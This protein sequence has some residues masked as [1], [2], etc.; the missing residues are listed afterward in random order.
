MLVQR[1][2]LLPVLIFL[3]ISLVILFSY[4]YFSIT[5]SNV[6]STEAE[7]VRMQKSF[8]QQI[9]SLEDTALALAIEAANNPDIQKA[10]A[11]QDRAR[12]Q[13]LTM[14]SYKQ[15]NAEFDIPQY[16]YHLPPA[17]SFLRLHQPERFGDDLSAIRATVVEANTTLKPVSGLE[18]GRGGLGI[19]G[20]VPVFY[21][22]RH[23]GAVEFGLN[24]NAPLFQNLK[25]ELGVDWQLYLEKTAAEVATFE[26]ATESIT[27]PIPELLLQ[28]STLATPLQAPQEAYQQ[29]LLGN[30]SMNQ[31]VVDDLR[32]AVMTAPLYD[33]SGQIIGVLEIV[34]DRTDFIRTNQTNLVISLLTILLVFGLAVSLYS[35]A[36]RRTLQPIRALV[37]TAETIASG[38]LNKTVEIKSGDEFEELGSVFNKMTG[39]LREFILNLEKRV[40]ERTADIEQSN[41]QL[42]RRSEELNILNKNIE[43]R[44]K[45][46]ETISEVS[47]AIASLEET[48]TLLPRITKI[49]SEKFGFYHVGIFLLDESRQFA[50]LVAS[51]SEGGQ[52]M[53]A[54]NHRLEVGKVGIV[55]YVTGTGN[56]RIALDTGQ[57]A[58]FFNNPD[59]PETHSEMALPLKSSR[60]VVGALD[61]Q[62][63][64][65]E[66]FTDDDL[67]VLTVLA[68]QVSSAIENARVYE[69][70]Q[71]SMEEVATIYR[72]YIRQEWDRLANREETLGYRYTI[73]GAKPILEKSAKP[74][75]PEAT[76]QKSDEG[77]LEVPIK[78]RDETIGV[79]NIR[80]P[81]KR[82]WQEDEIAI[83]RAVADRVAISAENARL[84]E[85]T[86][87]RA[88]RERKVS[89]ITS[90]IRSTNDPNEMLTIALNEIKQALKV[91][92]VKIVPFNPAKELD[93][94]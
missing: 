54:R 41:E 21:E 4:T 6:S 28:T 91:K 7:L 66:A 82:D 60:G 87:E 51:N 69:A 36:L 22:G 14:E 23:I 34:L 8:A 29:A 59:L 42:A 50:I 77:L 93:Q 9:N 48:E 39:Q 62:S 25:S 92:D 75:L 71:K 56:P 52:R 70:T 1:K 16:Q 46:L 45:Q 11:E 67:Q 26:S 94:D 61:V 76:E 44:A 3:L 12:L 2:L 17:T 49:I 57:D 68:N 19:R 31:V 84:F 89:E 5:T 35:L 30:R 18:I 13:A 20:V 33:Y 47:Q 43:R 24:V 10:F 55:G 79:L 32:Y 64:L 15:L 63:V 85:Q 27:A 37:E 86:I 38:D 90:R 80:T 83:A 74:H 72:Q 88:E 40:R 78:L 81:G 73:T 58:V 65:P 53:L